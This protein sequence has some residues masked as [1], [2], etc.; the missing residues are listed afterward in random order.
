M[1]T[2]YITHPSCRLHEMGPSH[3][4]CPERL[5]AINDQLLASG[6]LGFM[7]ERQAVA[8]SRADL[9]RM[10]T[11]QYL[12]YLRAHSPLGAGAYF[13]LDPD[14]LMN[15]HTLDAARL[16]AGAGLMAV[17]AIM[18]GEASTAFCSVRPPGHHARPGLAM[19][20]C[21]FNNLAVAVAYAL[22]HYALTRVAIIDF[23]VHHGNGTEEMFAG[24]DRVL[25]CSFF[26]HPFYPYCG[27]GQAAEN[28]LNIPV[29]AYTSGASLRQVMSDVWMPRLRA[30]EPEFI[31]VSAGFDAH[32]EDDMG[33]LGMV[34]SDYAW[35]TQ[36]IVGLADKT[37]QGRIISFLEG[38]YNLS[39][40]GRSVVAHIKALAKL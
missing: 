21:I 6:V 38:G 20:F 19:G 39:A 13:A 28:M 12:D 36:Q 15:S 2:L 37:A 17:D 35:M 25:M 10:H 1:Q 22:D 23:D 18:R 26:Q 9:L 40:L 29:A 7:D 33:Q 4:E 34:E 11:P 24:D 8:A 32:R 27:V 5:D 16:A 31:F 14:T 3:P 30:F